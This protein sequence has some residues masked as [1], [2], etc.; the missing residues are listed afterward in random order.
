MGNFQRNYCVEMLRAGTSG[1]LPI[2]DGSLDSI[3]LELLLLRAGDYIRLS[4]PTP[5]E[6]RQFLKTCSIEDMQFA[7][8]GLASELDAWGIRRRDEA[9]SVVFAAAKYALQRDMA[10]CDLPGFLTLLDACSVFDQ[11]LE[12]YTWD[13]M[14]LGDRIGYLT[15]GHWILRYPL[16]P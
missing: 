3:I 2:P 11:N 10:P 12:R 9:E 5:P 1:L 6:L 4:E 7:L 15:P 14:D 16:A 13:L 8:E